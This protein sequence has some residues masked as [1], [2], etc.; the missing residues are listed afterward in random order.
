MAVTNSAVLELSDEQRNH[1][2]RWLVAFERSWHKGRLTK[3][4]AKL[5][6]S[7]LLRRAALVEMVKIDLERNW[8]S[9]RR[10]TSEEYAE[11][12]PELP[13]PD[14]LPLDVIQTEFE[15][16]RRAGVAADVDEFGRRFPSRQ[17]QL[18]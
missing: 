11:R 5:P 15:A 18:R 17:N 8:M 1:L 4:V 13:T 7:G 14:G 3:W 9:G 2:E 10:P 16:R 6:P 12:F